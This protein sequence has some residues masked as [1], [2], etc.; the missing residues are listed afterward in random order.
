M[1]TEKKFAEHINRQIFQ[2]ASPAIHAL[3]DR[4]LV[5]YGKAVQ[6][7]LFYGSCLRMGD[8]RGGLVDLYVLVDS[9]R[10]AYRRPLL[11]VLNKL[12]PPNV[13]YLEVPYKNR[14]VRAKYAVLSLTD[15]ECGTS[16]SWFHSYIWGRFAQPTGLLY[17][18]NNQVTKQVQ[19]SL[20]QAVLT[21]IARALPQVPSPFTARDLWRKGLEL[22]YRAE[23]RAERPHKLI[24]LFE[25][26]PDYYEH[27]TR[28]ALATLSFPVDIEKSDPAHHYSV[29]IP[30]KARRTNRLDW[31]VR[32]WQG[33]ILSVLRL[34]KGTLTFR[35]GVDYILWKIERHSGERV[36]AS[37]RLKR[38]PLLAAC[39]ILWQLY[40]RGAYR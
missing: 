9:Y 39:V 4:L 35:G 14:M 32:S 37:P 25:A 30:G 3:S 40:R 13:F 5:T 23:L 10:A 38:Y 7:I 22:S 19:S 27:I 31:M 6:A 24:R 28:E 15:F 1:P 12:L 18:R 26:A 8:D 2:F 29:P 20:A 17:A 34:L 33:K 36:E 11:A 21:F 16:K